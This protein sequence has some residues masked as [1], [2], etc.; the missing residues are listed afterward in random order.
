MIDW[1]TTRGLRWPIVSQKLLRCARREPISSRN[2]VLIQDELLKT[3]TT[4]TVNEFQNDWTKRWRFILFNMSHLTSIK[5]HALILHGYLQ[6]MFDVWEDALIPRIQ[7]EF[8]DNG[9]FTWIF[10]LTDRG[11]RLSGQR[12]FQLAKRFG[13][14]I[15]LGEKFAPFCDVSL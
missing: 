8:S 15:A 13:Q 14:I 7:H 6:T 3:Y 11:V 5:A 2:P 4:K 12:R 9:F 10:L 1:R